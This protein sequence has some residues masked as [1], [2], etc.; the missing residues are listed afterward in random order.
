[1]RHAWIGLAIII[2]AIAP[3]R[4][5]TSPSDTKSAP[6]PAENMLNDMLKPTAAAPSP[7]TRP[8]EVQAMR[9]E[10]YTPPAAPPELLR[11][12]SDVIARRG[13]L[14]N[15][16]MAHIP[17]SFSSMTHLKQSSL[18]CSFFRISSL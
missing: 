12:G 1:M 17:K 16:P 13:S 14:E 3:L 6:S 4:A 18:R 5:Q 8:G 15:C 2:S 7:T 11:E 9:P 10:G